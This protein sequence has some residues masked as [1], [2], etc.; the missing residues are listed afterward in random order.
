MAATAWVWMPQPPRAPAVG[1]TPAP[2][3]VEARPD[4]QEKAEAATAT[5]LENLVRTFRVQV[6]A[7]RDPA[8]ADATITRVRAMMLPVNLT[9][10]STGLRHITVGPYVVRAQA[11]AAQRQLREAGFIDSVLT[12]IPPSGGDVSAADRRVL[13][14]AAELAEKRDVRGLETLRDTWLASSGDGPTNGSSMAAALD[15]YLDGARRVQLLEDRRLLIG[16][17]QKTAR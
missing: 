16:D 2:A 8:G 5:P 12:D 7:F 9:V 14:R 11:S 1:L 3:S 15:Q 4:K 17:I 6:G 13:T 10:G